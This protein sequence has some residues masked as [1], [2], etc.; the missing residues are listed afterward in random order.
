MLY[1]FKTIFSRTV[2]RRRQKCGQYWPTEEQ[3]SYEGFTV[4]NE[5]SQESEN[6]IIS[7]LKLINTKVSFLGIS[8]EI[9]TLCCMYISMYEFIKLPFAHPLIIMR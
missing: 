9:L 4:V 2:E 1:T 3:E 7:T 6:Y 5:C 8:E